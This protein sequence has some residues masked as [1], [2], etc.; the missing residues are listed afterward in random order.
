MPRPTPYSTE[1][2][3]DIGLTTYAPLPTSPS[4]LLNQRSQHTNPLEQQ[5]PDPGVSRDSRTYLPPHHTSLRL[6]NT[7]F[8]TRTSIHSTS[9]YP[10]SY[11][12]P[13]PSPSSNAHLGGR[14]HSPGVE[15]VLITRRPY[16]KQSTMLSPLLYQPMMG[17]SSYGCDPK[18]S[19][20]KYSRL[21]PI[22]T[23]T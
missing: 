4:L 15:E 1:T 12:I 11:I 9:Q 2:S 17:Q 5:M 16:A 3:A 6:R 23:L 22:G 8:A 21:H 10:L 20:I 18:P 14:R 7:I 19:L 13:T